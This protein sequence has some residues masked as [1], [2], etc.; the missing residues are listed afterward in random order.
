MRALNS[1]RQQN[2]GGFLSAQKLAL[3]LNARISIAEDATSGRRSIALEKREVRD[4]GRE[5]GWADCRNL[6]G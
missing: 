6:S 5:R 1:G 4:G 2:E 3:D